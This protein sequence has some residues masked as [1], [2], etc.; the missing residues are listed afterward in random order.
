MPGDCVFPYLVP[1]AE[2]GY[3]LGGSQVGSRFELGAVA[4]VTPSWWWWRRVGA[5]LARCKRDRTGQGHGLWT[6]GAA[7]AAAHDDDWVD[8][9]ETSELHADSQDRSRNS[10]FTFSVM[11]DD[12][13]TTQR[14]VA[15]QQGKKGSD[16]S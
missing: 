7:G 6:Q 9:G 2:N 15:R 11:L 8:V 3:V 4:G 1:S 5:A 13:T 12:V 10:L 16:R 14:V